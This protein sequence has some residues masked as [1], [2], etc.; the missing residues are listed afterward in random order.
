MSCRFPDYENSGL[1][2]ISSIARFFGAENR[3]QTMPPLDDLL[4]ERNYRNVVLFLLDG[5]GMDALA[6]D[7]P[8]DGFFN[9]HIRWNLS[10]VY[11]STTTAAT[12][13]IETD[14][15]PG[16]HGWL[17]WSLYFHEIDRMVDIFLN[18]ISGEN[19]PA[20]DYNVAETY[21]PLHPVF[22]RLNE[23]GQCK[24]ACISPFGLPAY[25]TLEDIRSA[26]VQGCGEPGRHFYYA[27]WGDPDHTMHEYGVYSDEVR[28]VLN[29]LEIYI[30]QLAESLPDNTLMLVTADHGLIDAEHLFI[31][32]HPD[33]ADA[34]IRPSAVE[35]R[36]TVFYVKP[37]YLERFPS[38]FHEAFPEGFALMTGEEFR[39]S[40][41]LGPGDCQRKIPELTGDFV[42]LSLTEKCLDYARKEYMLHG[43]H[44]GLTS[45][46]MR[47][48]LIIAKG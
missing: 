40:N 18:R 9:T 30:R 13:S 10:A 22:D 11:P 32:D 1:N 16:E 3:H 23:R 12:T 19:T 43:V 27:Y 20:A 42:A 28:T 8:A 24:A 31:T 36:T 35:P 6:H 7:C 14:Y 41:I 4:S 48:P 37:E 47:V 33:L 44:A 39:T 25:P 26:L 2:V 46:E 21:L 17:G 38:L 45:R 34:L 15:S 29:D 5:M